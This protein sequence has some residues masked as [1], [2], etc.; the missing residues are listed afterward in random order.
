MGRLEG[1]QY[2]EGMSVSSGEVSETIS[3]LKK[4]KSC[5]PDGIYAEVLK[6]AHRK[7]YV[8]LSVCI[9]SCMTHGY[10]AQLL[11]EATIVPIIKKI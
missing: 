3:K 4:G 9:S 7:V 1:I 6:T 10:M 2:T 11:I 5:G 8:L